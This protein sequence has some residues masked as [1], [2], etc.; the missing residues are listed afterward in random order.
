MNTNQYHRNIK[1][2]YRYVCFGKIGHD[3][4]NTM[5]NILYHMLSEYTNPK[6]YL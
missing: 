3:H 5:R 6:Y 4:D 2:S 1:P